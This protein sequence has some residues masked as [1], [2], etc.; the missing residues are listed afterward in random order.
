MRQAEVTKIWL[1]LRMGAQRSSQINSITLQGV[2]GVADATIDL[3]S[4]LTAICGLNG[5]G[6]SIMLRI[7]WMAL[8]PDAAVQTYGVNTRLA[9]SSVRVSLVANNQVLT[10][11]LT[12][13]ALDTSDPI[14]SNIQ[15][16]FLDA[17]SASMGVQAF[18][19]D[20]QSIPDLLNGIDPVQLDGSE[21]PMLCYVTGKRYSSIEFYEIDAFETPKPYFTATER[22]IK[23]DIRDMST[24]EISCFLLVW[25]LKRAKKDA[26]ILIDEPE[27]YIS[28]AAQNG[29]MNFF[30]RCSLEKKLSI[31]LCTHSP[32]FIK[33]LEA[34]NFIM[35]YQSNDGSKFAGRQLFENFLQQIG[36]ERYKN[37]VLLVEDRFSRE[38]CS[39]LLQRGTLDLLQRTAVLDVGGTA[40]LSTL[41]D[42]FPHRNAPIR[43]VGAYDGDQRS[44][45]T[46]KPDA[47]PSAF[48]PGNVQFEIELRDLVARDPSGAARCLGRD[49][50]VVEI[51]NGSLMGGDPH[52]WPFQLAERLSMSYEILLRALFTAWIADQDNE[53]EADAFLASITRA[54]LIA[55]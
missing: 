2:Q 55:D 26:I 33:N 11:V 1:D 50:D 35:M 30:A 21:L 28:P 38:F 47:W 40:K 12:N 3:R 7:I 9:R 8:A 17:P 45:V 20:V 23:Y 32:A 49:T 46:E 39:F 48:L 41:L 44:K 51:A 19:R 4:P 42:F 54:L 14:P 24:G 15:V 6:K 31:V 43:I 16:V 10:R 5:V 13:G 34:D 52:D 53:K 18:F 27:T 25:H 22:G 37:N 36:I 29:M